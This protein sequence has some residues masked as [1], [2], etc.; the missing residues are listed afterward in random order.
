MG[1]MVCAVDVGMW[2]PGYPGTSAVASPLALSY[3]RGSAM[4]RKVTIFN[5][6]RGGRAFALRRRVLVDWRKT[7]R[8]QARTLCAR[9]SV[10]YLI[11]RPEA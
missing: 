8:V 9:A 5:S 11:L 1:W 6:L 10:R 4:C 3:G 7:V 2:R